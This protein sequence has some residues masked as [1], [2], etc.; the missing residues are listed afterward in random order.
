M[1]FL[2][3]FRK[4]IKYENKFVSIDIHQEHLE[5][6]TKQ[7]TETYKKIHNHEFYQGCGKPTCEWCNFTMNQKL[8]D[9]YHDDLEAELDE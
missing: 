9:T 7:I 5:T 1:I 3:Y 8:N 2:I 6:V 4:T